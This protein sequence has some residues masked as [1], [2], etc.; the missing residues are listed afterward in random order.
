MARPFLS[1][2]TSVFSGKH[3]VITGGSSGLG[4]ELGR[5]LAT[6]GARLTLVARDRDKLSRAQAQLA[7]E[8]HSRVE[9]CSCDVSDHPAVEESFAG[10]FDRSGA[11]DI[12]ICSA[13]ILREG[14][15]QAQS[16]A[17]FQAVMS[18]NF[19]GTLHTIKAVLPHFERAGS[20]RIVCIASMA[21]LLGAFGYSAYCSSKHAV[22]GLCE[23]LRH[24]L[25]PRGITVQVVCPPE[26]GSPMVTELNTYRSP[27]NRALVHT[28]PVMTVEAVAD[29][30]LAGISAGRYRIIPGA[31]TRALELSNRLLPGV[32]RFI[33]DQRLRQIYRGPRRKP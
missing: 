31:V 24:E 10:I 15:F 9:I 28:L 5:R 33:A 18:V 4:L 7:A 14:Y 8:G 19:F 30:I 25:K 29:E 26:F 32:S 21:G 23:T 12:L 20:G 22:V 17:T 11:V 3:I 16:V 13:G 6:R 1:H 27:E 2:R